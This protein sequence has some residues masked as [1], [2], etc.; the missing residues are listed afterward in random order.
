MKQ[1]F[2]HFSLPLSTSKQRSLHFIHVTYNL[3]EIIGVTGDTSLQEDKTTINTI[4]AF[5]NT[6]Q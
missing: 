1:L 6:K 3:P 4:S 2:V 5:N